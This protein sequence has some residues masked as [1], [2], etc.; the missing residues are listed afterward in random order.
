MLIVE[1]PLL[2]QLSD[3]KIAPP[4][5][6]RT[7]LTITADA[8]KGLLTPISE[9]SSRNSKSVSSKA[10]EGPNLKAMESQL[11]VNADGLWAS[12]YVSRSSRQI[13]LGFRGAFVTVSGDLGTQ[14]TFR[15]ARKC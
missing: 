13:E 2:A 12:K 15:C 7:P 5:V 11:G 4:D 9:N 14:S 3:G 1:R 8:S 6:W 10:T